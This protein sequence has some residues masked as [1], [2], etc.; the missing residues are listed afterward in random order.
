M[1]LKV[2]ETHIGNQVYVGPETH[3]GPA[4]FAAITGPG[5]V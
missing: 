3:T 4:V 1:S 5:I 2:A